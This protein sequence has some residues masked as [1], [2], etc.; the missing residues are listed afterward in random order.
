MKTNPLVFHHH[1]KLS[2]TGR[3]PGNER[4]VHSGWRGP[5]GVG[6]QKTDGAQVSGSSSPQGLQ[7]QT[8]KRQPWLDSQTAEGITVRKQLVINRII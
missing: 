5:D 4:G 1:N 3:R 8:L 2:I 6:R 7:V